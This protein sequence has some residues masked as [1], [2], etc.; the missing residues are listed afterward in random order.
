VGKHDDDGSRDN[1]VRNS[2]LPKFIFS[3]VHNFS[4]FTI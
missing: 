4:I 2:L 3:F 1:V